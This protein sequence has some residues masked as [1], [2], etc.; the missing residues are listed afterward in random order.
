MRKTQWGL[1]FLTVLVGT[2]I[3]ASAAHSWALNS[4]GYSTTPAYVHAYSGFAPET[5]QAISNAAGQWNTA[6]AGSL[7]FQSLPEHSLTTYPV[8]NNENDITR[9]NRGIGYL[10]ETSTRTNSSTN[11]II[12]ADID[13]NVY[14]PFASD[15]SSGNYDVGANITHE[16]GHLLGLAHSV[17]P[18]ATMFDQSAL[19]ETKKRT[20]EQDDKNGI[21]FLYK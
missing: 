20:I 9:G 11:K 3:G 1:G 15:G 10:M 14:Y 12:E 13:I 16:L 18:E 17:D 2:T 5:K 4:R 6:G 21:L 8:L 19:G 7:V